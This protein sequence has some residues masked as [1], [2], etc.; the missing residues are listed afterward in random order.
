MTTDSQPEPANTPKTRILVCDDSRVVRLTAKKMLSDR[1]DLVLAEDGEQGWQQIVEDESIQMVFTDLRMPNLDGFDLIRRVRKSEHEH[2]RNMPMVVITGSAEEEGIKRQIFEVGATDFIS[3]PFKASTLLARTEAHTSYRK[4]KTDLQ[5]FCNIDPLAGVLNQQGIQEQ[6]E[7]DCAFV[8]RHA[9]KIAVMLFEID[10]FEKDYDVIGKRLA[11]LVVKEV[12]KIFV[13]SLRKEDS[14]GRV[15]LAR[16]LIVLPMANNESVVKLARRLSASVRGFKLKTPDG[17]KFFTASSGIACL[18]KSGEVNPANLVKSANQALANAH[19]I[20]RDQV[21]LL[22]LGPDRSKRKVPSVSLDKLLDNLE[23]VE[24]SEQQ[25]E[26]AVLKIGPLLAK[27]NT[28]QKKQL[29][30]YF[31]K[32]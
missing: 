6:L 17:N 20:G 16:F 11:E 31:P 14:V 15:G 25:L 2:I 22:K 23:K 8:S 19:S 28:A 21:Q 29:L 26:E 13:Q 7:K 18:L 9:E 3:K 30:S 24:P 4:I 10:A 12:A 32:D 5:E 27:M 1:F